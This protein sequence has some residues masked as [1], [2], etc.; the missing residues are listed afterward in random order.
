MNPDIPGQSQSSAPDASQGVI[1]QPSG[2]R[3]DPSVPLAPG[4]EAPQGTPGTG[5]D[6]CPDCG[7]SGKQG[8][9]ACATCQ[10]AGLV[11][12]GIGGA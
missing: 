11:T 3:P 1:D 9:A 7:G 4:D 10:G 5:E 12:V 8:A 6:I 2:V